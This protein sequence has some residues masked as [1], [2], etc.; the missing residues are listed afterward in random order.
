[1]Y[2]APLLMHVALSPNFQ[3]GYADHSRQLRSDLLAAYDRFVPPKSSR[4]LVVS[5]AGTDV[6]L[7][8]KFF[9]VKEVDASK[10]SMELKVW[11]R[12]YW[13]DERLSWDPVQY[14]GITRTHFYADP[15]PTSGGTELWLPDIQPYNGRQGIVHTLDPAMAQVDNTG[16][17]FLSRPGTLDVMCK[18]S[19]LVAFPF[20]KLLCAIEFGGWAWSGGHQGLL[21]REGVGYEFSQQE[22]ALGSSYQEYTIAGVTPMILAFVCHEHQGREA[23]WV[24]EWRCRWAAVSVWQGRLRAGAGGVRM[25]WTGRGLVPTGVSSVGLLVR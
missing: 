1:M 9:K 18:Y 11:L 6:E 20:D 2:I 19:G 15:A 7:S 22:V 13:K 24:N 4:G 16:A 10:G 21:L 3:R 8:I 23:A 17:V 5:E 25:G 12:M 14:G